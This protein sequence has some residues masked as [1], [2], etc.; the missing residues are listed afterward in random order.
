M[1][2]DYKNICLIG[3]MGVGKTSVGNLL[4]KKLS[5]P[6][7][8]TDSMVEKDVGL[9]IPEIFE[10]HGEKFFREKEYEIAQPTLN[11]KD[12]VIALGGGAFVSPNIQR[13]AKNSLVICLSS[14]FE[15]F[16]QKVEELKSSRPLLKNK[17]LE[18]IQ[19]LYNIRAACYTG[20]D[21]NINVDNLSAEEVTNK[22]ISFLKR[23]EAVA[24]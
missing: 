21:F 20:C 16:L 18:E 14:S 12:C 22:I 11:K 1:M 8:D 10:R 23:R 13:A 6:F 5:L 7:F 3:F 2:S 17:S 9:I 19:K 24:T 15:T 4:A